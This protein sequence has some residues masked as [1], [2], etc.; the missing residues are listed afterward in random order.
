MQADLVNEA[1]VAKV[2]EQTVSKYGKIDSLVSY[3]FAHITNSKIL[4]IN[5]AGIIVKGPVIDAPL[6][7]Y[8]E[9]MN[10]NVR[11]CVDVIS[12]RNVFTFPTVSSR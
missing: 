7:S 9:V 11:R 5:A 2:V 1:D 10:V 3:L 12:S 6:S 4:Q 8:D